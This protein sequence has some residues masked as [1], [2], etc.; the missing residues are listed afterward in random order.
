MTT[1]STKKQKSPSTK[2]VK[3]KNAGRLNRVHIEMIQSV[4]AFVFSSAY[5]AITTSKASFAAVMNLIKSKMETISNLEPTAGKRVTGYASLKK[6]MRTDLIQ[7]SIIIMK[8]AEAFAASPFNEP[9]F[10]AVKASFSSLF[11]LSNVALI[12]KLMGAKQAITPYVSQMADFHITPAVMDQW[13][14]QINDYNNITIPKNEHAIQ[15]QAKKEIHLILAE[16]MDTFYNKADGLALEFKTTQPAY[17][18]LYTRNRKLIPLSKHTKFRIDIT[19]ELG[20]PI[21][22]VKIT[23]DQTFNASITDLQGKAT[24]HIKLQEGINPLYSF[25]LTNG[26]QT[27]NTGNVLINKG[28]TVSAK[29]IM[30]PT[31]F[32]IPKE[33]AITKSKKELVT[34]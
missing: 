32:I 26:T 33:I 2:M 12:Q 28:E 29:I 27:T 20:Q 6:R 23:Q 11:K 4:L 30:A 21:Q 7:N 10:E 1:I 17:Y 3:I 22:G 15:N 13:T 19:D 25:T 16:I 8:N 31:G 18:N 9:L 34:K 24:L 14:E 5:S